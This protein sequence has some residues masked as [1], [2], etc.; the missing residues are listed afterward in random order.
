MRL[1]SGS[2][3]A[4]ARRHA[5]H[6]GQRSCRLQKQPARLWLH[7]LLSGSRAA[8]LRPPTRISSGACGRL[9]GAP[10]R[11]RSSLFSSP[12]LR[13]LH[14]A[15]PRSRPLASYASWAHLSRKVCRK[16]L[17]RETSAKAIGVE[18]KV[19]DT[20]TTDHPASMRSHDS[21]NRSC[22]GMGMIGRRRAKAPTW[23]V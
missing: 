2:A 3:A 10:G 12:P 14:G 16:R 7:D 6:G 22:L 1:L 15:D 4:N 18:R 23:V 20:I 9:I 13:G 19:H 21:D 17:K 5:D 11:R 8:S